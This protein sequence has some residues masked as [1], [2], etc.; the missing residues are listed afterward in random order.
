PGRPDIIV[1]RARLAVFVDGCFWHSCPKCLIPA[2]AS[3]TEYWGPKL[4]RNR[5]RDQRVGRQ[6]RR[7][8]W[9]PLRL[10]EHEVQRDFLQAAARVLRA[11]KRLQ[12]S[13]MG[14]SSSAAK[15][16]TILHERRMQR[17]QSLPSVP[18]A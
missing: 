1:T 16:R 14:R 5:L 7:L 4:R 10:W 17:R 15:S 18:P 8:G 3:R 9:T 12:T 6:L 2:P 13:S 11:V